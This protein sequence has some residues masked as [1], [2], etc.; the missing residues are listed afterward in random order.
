[1]QFQLFEKLTRKLKLQFRFLKNK[2]LRHNCT[3]QG[4]CLI[5]KKN[6]IGYL[7]TS[8]FIDQSECLLYYLFCIKLPLF[9]TVLRKN[10]SVLS[11]SESSNFF[12]YII[13]SV[14]AAVAQVFWLFS[15]S[16]MLVLVVITTTKKERLFLSV[17]HTARLVLALYRQVTDTL[18]TQQLL[19]DCRPTGSLCSTTVDHLSA[20]GWPANRFFREPFTIIRMRVRGDDW[21]Q[22]Q[23]TS[24]LKHCFIVIFLYA[25]YSCLL[26]MIYTNR[27]VQTLCT[28]QYCKKHYFNWCTHELTISNKLLLIIRIH[29]NLSQSVHVC[30]FSKQIWV[31]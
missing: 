17:H 18:S 28:H 24:A 14:K 30:H 8:L 5:W 7:W 9:C 3:I 10:C 22:G 19:A 23:L 29:T 4:A 31:G 6:L 16:M 26:L 15:A 11:Q 27:K 13:K 1:M 25:Y 20:D 12:I 2:K 21:N